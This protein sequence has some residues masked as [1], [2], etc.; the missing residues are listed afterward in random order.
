MENQNN[1]TPKKLKVSAIQLHLKQCEKRDKLRDE[2]EQINSKIAALL[3]I[4]AE[5]MADLAG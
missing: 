1:K 5:M 4:R 3:Q 2:I